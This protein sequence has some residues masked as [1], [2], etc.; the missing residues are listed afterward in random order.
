MK[1]ILVVDDEPAVRSMIRNV[2]ESDGYAVC[3]A[4]N[5]EAAL[6]QLNGQ[7]VD[8]IVTDLVMPGKNGIDL[9]LELKKKY[10]HISILAISGGG[11]ISGR[12]DYLKIAELVGARNIMSKPFDTADFQST[13]ATM[14][15]ETTERLYFTNGLKNDK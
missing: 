4:V 3:E 5:G 14:L 9:I 11:G 7:P 15:T 13:V 2:L 10:P 12:F 8:L 1:N 6:R